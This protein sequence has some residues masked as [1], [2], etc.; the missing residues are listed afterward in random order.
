VA[1]LFAKGLGPQRPARQREGAGSQGGRVFAGV[2]NRPA[3]DRVEQVSR[4]ALLVRC[5]HPEGT[6]QQAALPVA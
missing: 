6:L 1:E 4:R 2:V 3:Q 5:E